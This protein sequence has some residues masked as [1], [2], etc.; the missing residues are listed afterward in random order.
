MVIS[1]D[2]K[3]ST[4]GIDPDLGAIEGI[5][6]G[7]VRPGIAR[8]ALPEIRA[9]E[10]FEAQAGT[11]D[12]AVGLF[13]DYLKLHGSRPEAFEEKFLKERPEWGLNPV[14]LNFSKR[15]CPL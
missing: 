13:R 1:H 7:R 2:V 9:F 10:E 4:V 12:Q 5:V 6:L 14:T 15:G 11:P 3:P 8:V